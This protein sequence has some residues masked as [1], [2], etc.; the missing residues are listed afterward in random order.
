MLIL[1]LVGAALHF[2]CTGAESSGEV[3]RARH[4][5]NRLAYGPRPGEISAV[6][7][8]GVE[9]WMRGQLQPDKIENPELE[10]RLAELTSLTSNQSD[11]LG[12]FQDQMQRRQ[13]ERGEDEDQESLSRMDELAPDE[14]RFQVTLA[15]GELQ[16]AKLL[17]A[18]YSERQLEEVLVDF[19]FNHFNVDARK[20]SVIAMVGHH[21][22]EV[23]RPHVFGKFRDLLGA[24]ARSGAMLI[25]LDNARSSAEMHPAMQGRGNEEVQR[26]GRGLNE[27][28]AREL[29]EL[30]TLGVKGGYS[31]KDVMEVARA[32]T[33]WTVER[34]TG[35]FVFRSRLHDRGMKRVLGRRIRE[36]GGMEDGEQVLD[37]LAAHPATARRI[38]TKLCQRFVSDE[39]PNDLVERVAAAFKKSK[40]DL[41]VTYEALF[42][43]PEFF[44]P[45]HY[46]AKIKTPFEFAASALRA[47]G[48]DLKSE[49]AMSVWRGRMPLRA[50]EAAATLGRGGER[51][52][53]RVGSKT[54][55][56]HIL[57]MG[58]PLYAWAAPTGYPEESTHWVS[59]GALVARLN[60]ALALA[61]GELAD[62]G[63]APVLQ[64]GISPQEDGHD[65][66][67][68]AENNIL[69]RRASEATRQVLQ[70][71]AGAGREGEES[72]VD[73]NRLLALLLGS[74]EF[75]RR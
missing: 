23:I 34:S 14:G 60:F 7:A 1:L 18:V 35:E 36:G 28:Y 51:L 62:V 37:L 4:V 31:Q 26:P 57:E 29:M 41:R 43:D 21:E 54:V 64:S 69:G 24:T 19:W 6:V 48:I 38:A 33:G 74:P 72:Q 49:A 10:G 17:R 11:L 59:A 9:K 73:Q 13:R 66:L 20:Q 68:A 58:M 8:M 46:D 75:Q 47:A 22:N 27:N 53:K 70:K 2:D 32:F 25:Y 52:Q 55:L 3:L 71:E 5:L 61:G 56:L 40:G 65:S 12:A 67:E 16:R 45:V 50:M 44:N 30:H 39:P 15:L 63:E 42:F